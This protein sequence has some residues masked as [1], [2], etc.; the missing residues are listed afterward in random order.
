MTI[1]DQIIPLKKWSSPEPDRQK[2][3]D[4]YEWLYD[5]IIEKFPNVIIEYD[6]FN[7]DVDFCIGI[8]NEEGSRMFGV[9]LELH[10]DNNFSLNEQSSVIKKTMVDKIINMTKEVFGAT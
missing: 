9:K 1:M 8:R 5:I 4:N 7:W 3:L 10:F 2:V 6:F